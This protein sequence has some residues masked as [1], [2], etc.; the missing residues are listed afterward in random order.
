[1][2]NVLNFDSLVNNFLCLDQPI[3]I[4]AIAI[5]LIKG[6]SSEVKRIALSDIF[7]KEV[8]PRGDTKYR[9]KPTSNCVCVPIRP[10]NAIFLSVAVNSFLEKCPISELATAITN[11]KRAK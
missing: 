11:N 10:N 6:C 8:K 4:K 1:M 3:V 2:A 9:I 5:I 7:P